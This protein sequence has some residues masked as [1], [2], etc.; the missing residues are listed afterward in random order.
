MT[1]RLAG[2]GLLILCAGITAGCETLPEDAIG[3]IGRTVFGDVVNT[4]AATASAQM[5]R[6]TADS[7]CSGDGAMC[8]NITTVAIAGFTESFT[9]QLARGDVRRMSEARD[10]SIETGEP[11]DWEN[12]D[13]G[14]SGQVQTRQIAPKPPEPTP[15]K[16]RKDQLQSLPMMDAVGEPYVVTARNGANVRGGPGTDYPVTD[17]LAGDERIHA[18][19]KVR[20]EDW[21]LVG[22]GQVGIGYVIGDL[23]ERW[24]APA[25]EPI[26]PPR[27]A[28]D[29][30]EVAEVQV[31]MGADCFSTT[32]KVTLANGRTEEAVV[33]SCRTPD[34]WVQV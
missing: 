32:N 6:E 30:Q 10:R 18:I 27:P 24:T 20:D 13:S 26:A 15:V 5:V 2:R 22:R 25:T 23:I 19:G 11:Q 33:T 7:L 31:E 1:R 21:Y 29:P 17:R 16:V 9:R 28:P 4:A 14:A 3:G 34:G 8:R 12:P